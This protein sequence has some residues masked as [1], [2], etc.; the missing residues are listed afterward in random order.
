MLFNT[1]LTFLWAAVLVSAF[2]SLSLP[3]K[4]QS[5]SR[6][7]EA[8]RSE[9]QDTQAAT[10]A[11]VPGGFCGWVAVEVPV[12]VPIEVSAEEESDQHD[13]QQH[14]EEYSEQHD[15]QHSNPHSGQ[16]SEEYSEQHPGQHSEQQNDN[17]K[18]QEPS[19]P[20]Q[21]LA[22]SV[23]WTWDTS[24]LKNV[25]PVA[26]K[27]DSQMYY[28]VAEPAKEGYFAF[29]TYRFTL[30]SV[31]LD[32]S[33]H[34]EVEYTES[35]D[36]LVKFKT[37]ESFDRAAESWKSSEDLLLIA[38]AKGCAG[39]SAEDRCYFRA[40]SWTVNKQKREVVA[41]GAPEHPENVMD[42]AKTEWGLWA[43]HGAAG[44]NSTGRAGGSFNYT[45]NSSANVSSSTSRDSHGLATASFGPSFD[46]A[47]DDQFG[48]HELRADS[49]AFIQRIITDGEAADSERNATT[50]KC[51]ESVSGKLRRRRL[52]PRGF[53]SNLWNGFVD[54]VKTAYNTVA[55]ALSIQGDFNEPVSW[56]L[57]G[58]EI[59]REAS[60]WSGNSIALFKHESASES[61][62]FQEH[63]NIYCVDCGVSG[64]AVFS[65]KAKITPLKGI[66]DGEVSVSTNMKIVLKVG[67]DA[68]IKY[69]KN[70]QQ[71]LFAFGL[72]G[73]SY[74][75]VTVGPYISVAAK[76]GL[77]AAAKG[78][79]LVGG[80]MGL[81]QAS[82]TLYVFQPSR[83][84]AMGWTPY[85]KP[86][87]DAEGEIMLAAN[88]AL[89]I[90]I[91][92][93]LKIS[94]FE[95]ALGLVEEP[96]ISAAAQVAGSASY[97]NANGFQ[98]GFAEFDG[99][100]GISA[101]LNWRN[102]LSIDVV[103][104]SSPILHDTGLQPIIK[105]CLSLGKATG[106][107]LNAPKANA[108]LSVMDSSG[109]SAAPHRFT[110]TSTPINSQGSSSA[111]SPANPA[112]SIPSALVE[113]RSPRTNE[114]C[115]LVNETTPQ[116]FKDGHRFDLSPL[117]TTIGTSMVA[118]C[119]DGN[120][121]VAAA[122]SQANKKCNSMWPAT[123]KEAVIPFDG[124]LNVMHYYASAMSAVGVSR[125]RS[126][127]AYKMPDDAVVT[128]LVPA[129]AADG[130]FFYMAA[131]ASEQVF[132]PIVCEFASNAVPRVFLSK[133]LSA[134]IRM[135]EGGTVAES[136]TGAKVEKCFGLALSPQL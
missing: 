33:K 81:T 113:S 66:F 36:L 84:T 126:S 118:S 121:Y 61:G 108:L 45:A 103:G 47:L 38:T 74:G 6:S 29:L 135:L 88:A 21:T 8:A 95:V 92:V 13:E 102:K 71:D 78:K 18:H 11:A 60:P 116:V 12:E 23:H 32:H 67:V 129:P 15:E 97:D 73:L 127:P 54:A 30:P 123:S 100:A 112:A 120:V 62:E 27:E 110:N 34:V 39:P 1:I 51:K 98:G 9:A 2:P 83:S 96:I 53:W 4:W 131:D 105:T 20:S 58:P 70:I 122:S 87:L 91:K 55:D 40:N 42:S 5:S 64:Q 35:R 133:E 89:P 99:C 119:N 37:S 65:G 26:A 107:R 68:E 132:Y 43:P 69:S 46:R 56:D 136:I 14:T 85:F 124:N 80:E 109:T 28:G 72:P 115:S 59:P 125:L 104:I 3:K 41:T 130:S 128:V 76:V 50:N 134:G 22:P 77:E 117:L 111:Q 48:Y 63:V 24:S 75:I 19:A 57:P 7:V 79:L 49:H 101:S 82:A 90:S 94:S 25:E 44:S 106:S 31:N 52:R 10:S 86:V 93:G 114:S 16:H 17:Q